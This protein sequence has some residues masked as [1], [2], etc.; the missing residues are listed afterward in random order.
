MIKTG[1][2]VPSNY[3]IRSRDFQL[4]GRAL[5][6]VLNSSKSYSDM[7]EY[8]TVCK[9]TD[10]RLLDLV[11]KTVGFDVKRKYDSKDLSTVCSVFNSILREKGTK[12]AIED[13]VRAMLKAQNLNE[14]FQVEEGFDM[15]GTKK[16]KNYTI[17]IL[18]P[19]KLTDVALLEDLL[20]YI[21]PTGYVYNIV[22]ISGLITGLEDTAGVV[23][24][25]IDSTP[26]TSPELGRVYQT[27]PETGNEDESQT[28]LSVVY[29]N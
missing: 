4:I 8:N 22:T 10:I 25:S 5:D 6:C 23:E 13:C 14:N 27:T 1:I 17:N 29:S 16:I 9:N 7:I 11:A 24:Q 2:Q 18:I 26:Y 19:S 12:K 20:D 15:D 28:Q 3:Y 21:L